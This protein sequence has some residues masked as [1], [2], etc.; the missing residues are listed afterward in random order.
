MTRPVT[1]DGPWKTEGPDPTGPTPIRYVPSTVIVGDYGEP[2]VTRGYT[3]ISGFRIYDE[4]FG[5]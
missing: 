5:S 3:E 1:I 4:E 2:V